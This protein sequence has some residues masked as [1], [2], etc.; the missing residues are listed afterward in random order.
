LISRRRFLAGSAALA[1]APQLDLSSATAR[2]APWSGFPAGQARTAAAL[3]AVASPGGGNAAEVACPG[4]ATALARCLRIERLVTFEIAA[5]AGSLGWDRALEACRGRLGEDRPLGLVCWG[6]PGLLPAMATRGD[7]VTAIVLLDQVDL[8]T[9]D[10]V[11]RPDVLCHLASR[12]S[13]AEGR[14]IARRLNAVEHAGKPLIYH[15]YDADPGFAVPGRLNRA[16]DLAWRR[17][18]AFLGRQLDQSVAGRTATI[19]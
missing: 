1:F 12:Q 10:R 6:E 4:G 14:E 2:P 18:A 13:P 15:W 7:A 17:T 8:L 5:G 16:A 11:A 9:P 19:G 3:V